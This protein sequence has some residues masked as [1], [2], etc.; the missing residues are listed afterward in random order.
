MRLETE[1]LILRRPTMED[2]QWIF[3]DYAQD[4][5]VTKYMRWRPHESVRTTREFLRHVLNEWMREK[6][7]HWVIESKETGEG[8]GMIG[9]W[10]EKEHRAQ[11]GYVLSQK[12]WGKGYATEAARAVVEWAISQPHVYRVW[13]ICDVENRASARVLEKAGLEFEG[14]LHRWTMHS[15][16]DEPRDVLCY[17]RVM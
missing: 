4:P 11:F 6:E 14:V 2:A 10:L 17:A 12:H 9:I 1:R 7:F 13:A 16:S 15:I 3:D 5:E 8:L